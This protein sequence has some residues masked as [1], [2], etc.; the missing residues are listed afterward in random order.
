MRY[1]DERGIVYYVAPDGKSAKGRLRYSVYYA[2]QGQAPE[3]L[4]GAYPTKKDALKRL[5]EWA[6]LYDWQRIE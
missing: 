3:V 4:I 1:K 2:G 5:D 6:G